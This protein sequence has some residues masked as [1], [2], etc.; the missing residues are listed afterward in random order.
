VRY[1][2]GKL[3]IIWTV[4]TILAIG[5]TVSMIMIVHNLTR[6][7]Y[8]PNVAPSCGKSGIRRVTNLGGEGSALIV[9][10][11]GTLIHGPEN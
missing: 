2:A 10:K 5:V 7:P 3:W 8:H 11:N 1:D 6:G 9:C 4:S